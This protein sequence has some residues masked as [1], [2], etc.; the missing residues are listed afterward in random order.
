[1]PGGSGAGKSLIIAILMAALSGYVGTFSANS[2]RLPG[3]GG[4]GKDAEARNRFL[5][6]LAHRR[7]A[8]S[9][10]AEDSPGMLDAGL[11]KGISGNDPIPMRQLYKEAKSIPLDS[12]FFVFVNDVPEVSSFDKSMADR[13]RTIEFRTAFVEVLSD[14]PVKHERLRDKTL[15]RRFENEV[16]LKDAVVE[17]LIDAYRHFKAHGHIEPKMVTA[18]TK[19]WIGEDSSFA[20]RF[21][22]LYARS[23]DRKDYVTADDVRSAFLAK[24]DSKH[25][26]KWISQ[27]ITREVAWAEYDK[28]C[29]GKEKGY[30]RGFRNVVL[31]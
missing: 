27:S 17:I 20:A 29:G 25:S 4:G 7:I 2:L 22:K 5:V 18:A 10:E 12:T 13:V 3:R 15:Q 21:E 23:E 30:V 9:T 19:E 14:P 6:D 28:Y 24:Y 8:M 31:K 16:A 11:I 26:T 1:M